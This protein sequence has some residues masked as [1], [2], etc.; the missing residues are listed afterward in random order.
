MWRDPVAWYACETGAPDGP[1]TLTVFVG[2][3][4][5]DRLHAMA[6]DAMRST[7]LAE[8]AAALGPE[9]EQP[10]AMIV[11]DWTDDPVSGGA[12]SDLLTLDAAHDTEAILRVGTSRIRFACSEISP[13][14]PGYV[15]G[16]IVAGRLAAEALVADLSLQSAIA[17]SASGS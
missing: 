3:P 7:I 12:Y 10:E 17:T 13:S 1:V 16:A 2:G 4:S 6:P 11:R 14:F 5:A 15:E 9:A 8:L